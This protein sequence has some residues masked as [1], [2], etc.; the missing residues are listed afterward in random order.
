MMP[1]PES[2]RIAAALESRVGPNADASHVADSVVSLWRDL[3]RELTP[4]V[5][6]R[7]VSALYARALYLATQTIPLLGAPADGAKL[8]MDFGALHTAIAGQP[9]AIGL[10][11]GEL[12]FRTFYTLLVSMVGPELTERLLRDV[13]APPSSGQAAQDSTP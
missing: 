7:G 5:G 4:I 12:L 9:A 2:R 13:L 8:V 6:A 3:E 1:S 11:A 10:A